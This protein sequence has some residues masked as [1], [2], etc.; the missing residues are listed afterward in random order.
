MAVT[1][2]LYSRRDF[3]RLATG[4]F[5]AGVAGRPA[6]Q[7]TSIAGVR[8][9]AISYCFRSIPRP[10]SG[11][12]M[13]TIIDAFRRTGLTVC[14]LES[15]R[16]DNG[17]TAQAG[18]S[19]GRRSMNRCDIYAKLPEMLLGVANFG[20]NLTEDNN[21][22]WLPGQFCDQAEPFLTNVRFFGAYIVPRIDVL[23]SATF[24]STPGQLV[25]ANFVATNAYLAANSTLGRPLAGGQANMT[26]NIA[27][28]GS[29]Y[30]ERL[31]QL[32]LRI[33]K[34]LRYGRTRSTI[35]LDMYNALNSDAIRTANNAYASWTGP[36]YRP[37]S[38]LLARFFKVSATFDY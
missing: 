31:N 27:E 10:A 33:G 20:P 17:L 13:D 4:A 18:I 29:L 3:G 25:A 19:T 36:G 30:V 38:V 21:N 26:V 34:V 22:V 32:D 12:Y 28:P 14:E 2:V 6:A 15:A 16:L 7:Q 35:N 37:T 23:V 11:D 5:A 9:G 8:V 1:P 24:Q